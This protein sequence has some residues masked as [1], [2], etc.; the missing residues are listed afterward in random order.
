MP[1]YLTFTD[2]TIP[3]LAS[4]SYRT[5]PPRSPTSPP[6]TPGSVAHKRSL[7]WPGLL[8]ILRHQAWQG[9]ASLSEP[10]SH[11]L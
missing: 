5:Q 11:E 8:S 10:A 7:P 3:P 2:S 4:L 1:A 9:F 6:L